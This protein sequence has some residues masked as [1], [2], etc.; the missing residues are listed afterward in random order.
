MSDQNEIMSSQS[1]RYEIG[2]DDEGI[3]LRSVIRGKLRLSRR[4]ATKLKMIEHGITVNGERLWMDAKL[5]VGDVV[6]VRLPEETSETIEPQPI[7]LDIRYEDE[8]MLAVNKPAGLIVHPTF[9][10]Y[11]NTLANG[12]MYYWQERGERYRFRPVH[13]LDEQTSGVVLIAKSAYVHQQISLQLQAHTVEKTYLAFVHGE[14]EEPVGRLTGPI[15]RDPEQPHIR[16]VTPDGYPAITNYELL[17]TYREASLLRIQIETGR[18]HQIRVHMRE[19]GHP[20]IGDSLYT[21]PKFDY[22]RYADVVER[23]AL[24][25]LRLAFDH[26]ISGERVEIEAPLA[27]DLLRLQSWLDGEEMSGRGL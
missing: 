9:G 20:L 14:V 6:E 18:T 23:Q 25:A 21:L 2:P 27:D 7:P 5:H 13:R 17:Q 12:V 22:D 24:H 19:M 8:Y 10:H 3:S 1:L 11:A 26:P 16:I 15:D 4:L